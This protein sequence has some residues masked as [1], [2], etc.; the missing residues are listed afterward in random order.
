MNLEWTDKFLKHQEYLNKDIKLSKNEPSLYG[1]KHEINIKSL[2]NWV[3]KI[4]GYNSSKVAQDFEMLKV[5]G[6]I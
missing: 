4:K 3:G 2:N 6:Y 5:F 1:I